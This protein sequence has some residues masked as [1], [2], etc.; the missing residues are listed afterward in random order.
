MFD[1]PIDK[2]QSTYNTVT[3]KIT[4]KPKQEQNPPNGT[5]S[6]QTALS[7]ILSGLKLYN[8]NEAASKI[9]RS[10]NSLYDVVIRI[11][12]LSDLNTQGWEILVGNHTNNV[13]PNKVIVP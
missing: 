11:N 3:Q 5:S 9:Y 4:G 10:T 8:T 7:T 1:N 6:E 12:N 13:I 2:L